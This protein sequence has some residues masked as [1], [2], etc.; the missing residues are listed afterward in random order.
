MVF[1]EA[2]AR[3]WLLVHLFV[4]GALVASTTHLAVWLWRRRYK[5]ARTFAA[6][7]AALYVAAFALGNVI[8]PVYKVNVRVGYLDSATASP[9]LPT[10]ARIARWFDVK[11][12]V[13]ALGLP[14][15]LA[16]L[17][18]LLVWRPR[19]A[20]DDAAAI[21]GMVL[22]LAITVTLCAWIPAILGALTTSFRGIP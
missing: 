12:H 1:G 3:W 17:A 13:A 4:G 18:I 21:H 11:E 16:L 5:G 22:G 10:T 9:D 7:C 15:A 19:R 6:I 2:S 8:Y 14:V 20:D